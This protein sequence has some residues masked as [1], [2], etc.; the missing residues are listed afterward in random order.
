MQA[1]KKASFALILLVAAIVVAVI[2]VVIVMGLNL[3]ERHEVIQ[4]Q[5]ETSD[6]RVSS[7]VPGR[8]LAIRV[9][10]GDTVQPGDTLA[11]M[12]APDVDAKLA[13]A[14]AATQAAEAVSEKARN[15][16]Q[17]E[18]I[19]GAY[20]MWQKAKAGLEVA[21]KT[22]NRVN[23]LYE[24][25][26]MAEQKRDEAY[27][28]YQA[29]ISTEKAAQSQYELARNASRYEDRDA[30][31]AQ[32]ARAKAAVSE[33]RSYVKETVL[34]APH[35]GVVTEIY[36]QVGELVGT[37][38]PIMNVAMLDSAW[39]TFNVREDLLPGMKVG[40]EIRVFLP[41]LNDTVAARITRLKD[42]GSYAVW[43]ATKQLDRYDLKTF[44]VQAR[45]L[46]QQSIAGVRP[47]M[48]VILE[49]PAE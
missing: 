13:Q 11:I 35:A 4:G 2:V 8:I 45:P 5:V 48:S 19:Q 9:S 33:V 47:G 26:V 6:Y 21:E 41:A 16:A 22:Y 1:K 23:R 46:D 25:G 18:Q 17:K 42:V 49:Q 3:K 7:K 34:L 20:E 28:Q 44:E 12:D 38:A 27:A 15:G 37:G 39:F 40:S 29:M 43:K 31:A 14:Q 32:V 10:E 36:P 24:Q 30:A